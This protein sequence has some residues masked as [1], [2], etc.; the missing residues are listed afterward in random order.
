VLVENAVASIVMDVYESFFPLSSLASSHYTSPF[1]FQNVMVRV[2]VCCLWPAVQNHYLDRRCVRG[3]G[4]TSRKP[5]N[6]VPYET[7]IEI[8][9]TACHPRV[10][11]CFGDIVKAS[12][13]IEG[14]YRDVTSILGLKGTYFN[15]SFDS[16]CPNR[17]AFFLYFKRSEVVHCTYYVLFKTVSWRTNECEKGLMCIRVRKTSSVSIP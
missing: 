3:C 8:L 15:F 13:K 1:I 6:G 2:D 12:H 10:R 7:E 17:L 4:K 5:W 14:C 11:V 9:R 16:C